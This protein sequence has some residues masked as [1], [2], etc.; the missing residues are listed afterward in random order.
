MSSGFLAAGSSSGFCALIKRCTD[1]LLATLLANSG[2][3]LLK[4]KSTRSLFVWIEGWI[5]L[6]FKTSAVIVLIRLKSSSRS[7]TATGPSFLIFFFKAETDPFVISSALASVLQ[8]LW[9]LFLLNVYL[10]LL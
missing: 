4:N 1:N 8:F 3:K 2:V 10:L 9:L 5:F 6:S 7:S